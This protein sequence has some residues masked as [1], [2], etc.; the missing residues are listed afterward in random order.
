MKR[1]RVSFM[2]G[3]LEKSLTVNA[4]D[5]KDAGGM[6]RNMVA[7]E[8]PDKLKDGQRVEILGCEE[9]QEEVRRWT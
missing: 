8:W 7:I 5:E 4:K 3:D 1:Y 9:E 2:V 6:I